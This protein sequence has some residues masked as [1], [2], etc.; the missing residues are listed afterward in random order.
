LKLL[1]RRIDLSNRPSTRSFTHSWSRHAAHPAD[2]L[3]HQVGNGSLPDLVD[4]AMFCKILGE[5][6]RLLSKARLYQLREQ[7]PDDFPRAVA[8][9]VWLRSMAEHYSDTRNRLADRPP[10]TPAPEG[11]HPVCAACGHAVLKHGTQTGT[12]ADG[13]P[14]RSAVPVRDGARRSLT[15]YPCT[16]YRRRVPA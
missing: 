14:W 13:E 4:V 5:E 16:A 8:P 1:V 3:E 7:Q 6:G 12:P 9:G 2:H 11:R 15:A 10:R